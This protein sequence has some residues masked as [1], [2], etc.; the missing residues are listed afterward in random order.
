MSDDVQIV[1]LVRDQSQLY[2][3]PT[4]V[5]KALLDPALNTRQG[6]SEGEKEHPINMQ[7]AIELMHHNPHHETCINTKRD[8][9]VGLGFRNEYDRQKAKMKDDPMATPPSGDPD[10]IGRAYEVL[11]PLCDTTL[12]D[13]LNDTAE[14]YENTGNGYWEVV[15]NNGQIVSLW[16]L[17]APQIWVKVE[18]SMVNRHYV[19]RSEDGTTK[20]FAR[21]G[22]LEG[23]LS[24]PIGQNLVPEQVSEIIHFRKGTS[25]SRYYGLPTWLSAVPMIELGQMVNQQQF[26]FFKNRGV[27]EFMAFFIGQ[28]MNKDAWNRVTD[29]MKANIGSGN[30]HKSIALN[31]T[32][33]NMRVQVEKLALDGQQSNSFQELN[34]VVAMA[35]VTAHRVPPLLAGIQIPGK[36][37]AVNELPNAL[38]AFQTLYV[39]QQ[40]KVFTETLAKTVGAEFGL[41]W[42]DLTFRK[43]TDKFDLQKV[44]TMARMRTPAAEGN[45]DLAEGLRD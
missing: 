5:L 18:D 40:Q 27:P 1:K 35:I 42:E 25:R 19:Y 34:D 13:L 14:D 4:T 44:D 37:G 21:F 7:A 29:A 43:I 17:P 30:A 38:L 28:Q 16:H 12:Q 11:S 20:Y 32:D 36:L 2:L 31:I 22:D 33:P 41:T 9:I 15:R 23:F 26:D 45:R 8:A 39:D 6:S 24:R 10:E 3:K